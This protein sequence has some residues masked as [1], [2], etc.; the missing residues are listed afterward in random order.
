M[1]FDLGGQGGDAIFLLMPDFIVDLYLYIYIHTYFTLVF[2]A[3]S[4]DP[5]PFLQPCYEN[6]L[7]NVP[8]TFRVLAIVISMLVHLVSATTMMTFPMTLN[9]N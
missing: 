2:L 4:F 9:A 6:I 1:R 3:C 5:G 8:R 7:S